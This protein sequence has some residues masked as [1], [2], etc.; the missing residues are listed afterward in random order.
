MLSQVRLQCCFQPVLT[1]FVQ[2]FSPSFL[3]GFLQAKDNVRLVLSRVVINVL[4]GQW[5]R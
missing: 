2:P 4:G 1:G 3:C 5:A